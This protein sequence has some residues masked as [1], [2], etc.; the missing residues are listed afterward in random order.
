M[1]EYKKI[2]ALNEEEDGDCMQKDEGYNPYRGHK[3]TDDGVIVSFKTLTLHSCWDE[4]LP[5][6]DKCIKDLA[7]QKDRLIEYKNSK[8]INMSRWDEF[9]KK[10]KEYGIDI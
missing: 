5:R 10:A 4:F 2:L 1:E 7:E 9:V 8:M 3:I 6:F